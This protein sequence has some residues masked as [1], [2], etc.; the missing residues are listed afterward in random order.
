MV[1][2]CCMLGQRGLEMGPHV[3][4]VKN[5]FSNFTLRHYYFESPALIVSGSNNLHFRWALPS[6]QHS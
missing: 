5:S 2:R 6:G 1:K 4:L 3:H